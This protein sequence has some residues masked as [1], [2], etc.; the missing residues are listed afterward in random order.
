MQ[1]P[2]AE[3]GI[4]L[5]NWNWKVVRQYIAERCGISL[6]R[7]SCLNWL[8]RL[9]FAFKRP[10]KRLVKADEAKREAFVAE[11]AALWDEAHGCGAKIFFAD[12]A[13]FRADAELR[14]KWVM[15]G[16]PALVDSTSPRYGEKAS[17]YS[18]V[19]LETGEVEWMELEGNSNSGTSTAFLTQLREMHSGPLNVIWD[20]APAHRGEAVR[21]YLRTPGLGLRLLNLPGYSPDFN[22]DE[23]IWGWAREEATG[24]QCLGSKVKV[25]ERVGSFLA[26]LKSRRDEVKRRYRTVL[27][28]RAKSLLQHSLRDSTLT[29]NA[30]PTLALV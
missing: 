8:N 5:A 12:E 29:P 27:Q 13:H 2:P 23:A 17:Y 9:G 15:R 10:K 14:G 26:G 20:N 6:S 11:Y 30:H 1:E 24:N 4:E 7:S 25:Q 21:E 18:A 22:P 28:S 19:C 3:S 16:E